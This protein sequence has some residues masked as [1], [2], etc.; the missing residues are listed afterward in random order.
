MV[1][2]N[3][4]KRCDDGRRRRSDVG[5]AASSH[6]PP[7]LVPGASDRRRRFAAS[8]YAVA[9]ERRRKSTTRV[10][11]A[12]SYDLRV[13]RRACV[14]TTRPAGRLRSCTQPSS[15]RP[16][17]APSC[18][19]QCPEPPDPDDHVARFGHVQRQAIGR[20]P[21]EVA[22]PTTSPSKPRPSTPSV[23]V[24]PDRAQPRRANS[25][26]RSS[27]DESSSC[28]SGNATYATPLSA[29]HRRYEWGSSVSA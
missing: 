3:V 17:H 7:D 28:V 22:F 12:G 29:S 11:D 10:T 16:T 23:R 8:V 2:R 6:I 5:P 27:F 4:G 26:S 24:V 21:R 25:S 14:T 15:V 1:L 19:A 18:T 9:G 20:H 13:Y